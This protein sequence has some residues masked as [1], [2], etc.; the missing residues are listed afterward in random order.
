MLDTAVLFVYPREDKIG[1][2]AVPFSTTICPMTMI[3]HALKDKK[4][5]VTG[6]TGFIGGRLAERLARE[7]EAIVTGTGRNLEAVPQVV[8][9]GVALQHADLLDEEAM[10]QAMQGQEIVFHVAAWLGRHGTE[11]KAYALNVAATALAVRLA[12]EAGVKRFV[13]VSSIAAYGHPPKVLHVTEDQPLD[14]EQEVVYGRTKALGEIRA[15]ELGK[16]L[17]LEVTAV[18]PG[19]VYG[20]R[21]QSWTINMIELVC[22][23]TPVIFGDGTGH[24]YPVFIDNLVDGMLLT[25]VHPKAAGEAYN[26]C[27][28]VV[29][30]NEWFGFYGQMCGREPRRIPYWAA[31]ILVVLNKLLGLDLPL[32]RPRLRMYA[33]KA[34]FPATKAKEQLGFE[35]RVSIEEGM[36]ITEAWLREE[37]YLQ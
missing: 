30:F 17:G 6:A 4:V 16:E 23:G 8:E 28:P 14:T 36:K 2:T 34:E 32:N 31:H 12:A 7:E 29:T 25:A 37:G 24:A 21:A 26:M 22:K 20:P 10:R 33:L 9:A 15:F 13:H 35:S 11:Q 1:M 5:L 3:N 18:R 19:L 27:D